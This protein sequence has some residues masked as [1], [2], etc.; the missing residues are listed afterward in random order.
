MGRPGVPADIGPMTAALLSDENSRRYL[1]LSLGRRGGRRLVAAIAP[2]MPSDRH[3]ALRGLPGAAVS[4]SG[5]D[6][7]APIDPRLLVESFGLAPQEA[8][9]VVLIAGC[10]D[11]RRAAERMGIGLGTARWY[12]KQA[13]EKTG[14]HRQSDLLLLAAGF[15]DVL[16]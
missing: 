7:S 11:L 5:P 9:L 12:L 15:A 1:R 2:L 10:A 16:R 4:P 3:R 14:A 13:L 8:E 6:R